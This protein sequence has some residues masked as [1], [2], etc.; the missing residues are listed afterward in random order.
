MFKHL[1]GV[2]SLLSIMAIN[3]AFADTEVKTYTK[4]DGTVVKSYTRKAKVK[5]A[6]EM[7]EVKSYKRKDGTVVKG[8]T[9][10][11]LVKSSAK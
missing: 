11:K 2:L 8:Y 10:E 7:I 4:K 3:A 6:P 5:A 1:I 9:K